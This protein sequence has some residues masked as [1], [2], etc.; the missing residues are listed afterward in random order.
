MNAFAFIA[1]GTFLT[2]NFNHNTDSLVRH[3]ALSAHK[4][5]SLHSHAS[6][7]E[8]AEIEN[9][10]GDVFLSSAVKFLQDG[11]LI[12]SQTKLSAAIDAYALTGLTE[13]RL[14]LVNIVSQRIDQAV[15]KAGGGANRESSVQLE[16]RLQKATSTGDALM[17]KANEAYRLNEFPLAVDHINAA[18]SAFSAAGDGGMLARARERVLGNLYAAVLAEIE[19]THRFEKLLKL[20]RLGDLVKQKKQAAELGIDWSEFQASSRPMD[21]TGREEPK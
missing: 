21:S 11:D 2:G 9:D 3:G 13:Q 4:P 5:L 10:A 19:R 17:L 16:L 6:P 1:C 18:R 14:E 12:S 8:P 7:T 20:K 15:V